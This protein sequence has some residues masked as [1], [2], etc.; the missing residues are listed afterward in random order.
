MLGGCSF[1]NGT[2]QAFINV[3]SYSA[4]EDEYRIYL[5]EAIKN[6]EKV[7]GSDIWDTNFNGKPAADVAKD[8]ALNSLVAVKIASAKADEYKVKTDNEMEKTAESEAKDFIASYSGKIDLETVKKVMLEKQIYEKVK[9]AV[10]SDYIISEKD[11]EA[12]YNK[13]RQK[14]TD[15]KTELSIS[16]AYFSDK[17]VADG[18][19]SLLKE[20][21]DFKTASDRFSIT[22]VDGIKLSKS[23]YLQEFSVTDVQE[24]DCGLTNDEKGFTV[25]YI[26]SITAPDDESIT[27]KMHDDYKQQ[28]EDTLFEKTV[29]NWKADYKITKD[30]EEFK[31]ISVK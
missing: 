18:F 22:D 19:L 23:D 20:G 11:Y 14:Y 30:E 16:E 27:K 13:N 21:A 1:S 10:L 5:N 25:Y 31:K 26:D 12:F 9:N 2:K 29:D 6:F 3:G 17:T 15:D 28:T 24:H 7:G 8:S 4:S